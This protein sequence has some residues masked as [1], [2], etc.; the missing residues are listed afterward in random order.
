MIDVAAGEQNP[1]EGPGPASRARICLVIK[2]VDLAPHVGASLEV[3]ERDAKKMRGARPFVF[4]NLKI[5]SG[6]DTVVKLSPTKGGWGPECFR[7]HDI[8]AARPISFRDARELIVAGGMAATRLAPTIT[9]RNW[10]RSASR[11]RHPC[12]CSIAT[13]VS[14]VVQTDRLEVL[15]PDNR[16]KSN[17]SSSH[18][19]RAVGDGRRRPHRP[20][21]ETMGIALSSSF[22]AR[23]WARRSG[24]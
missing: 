17:Q 5:G 16:V 3:M 23:C 6:G 15:G 9:S 14:N 18:S 1:V 19:L 2:Q 4:T 8:S 11:G 12:R 7:S 13:A 20:Q 22:E 24:A 10:P 21:A